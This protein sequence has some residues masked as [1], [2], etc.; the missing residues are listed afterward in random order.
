M[1]STAAAA[2]ARTNAPAASANAP[3]AGLSTM[4][5]ILRVVTP[6]VGAVGVGFLIGNVGYMAH[7]AGS[8]DSWDSV[9]TQMGG[10]AAMAFIGV[11]FFGA[12]LMLYFTQF[13]VDRP[14]YI[15]TALSSLGIAIS[16][17]ALS[18]AS[19]TR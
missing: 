8:S 16:L 5:K 3:A 12:A 18:V 13:N 15:L 2:P 11:L 14:V 10:A 4:E 7:L 1:A 6:I 9:K 17:T 19:I